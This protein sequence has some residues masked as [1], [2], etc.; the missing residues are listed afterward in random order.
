LYKILTE[1]VANLIRQQVELLKSEDV[2]L[3]F[4]DDAIREI[5]RV[6]FTVF[7]FIINI[8]IIII[9]ILNKNNSK[10]YIHEI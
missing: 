8:F 7:Y 3:T 10:K 5:A 6:A 2:F 4:T 9:I 1:P